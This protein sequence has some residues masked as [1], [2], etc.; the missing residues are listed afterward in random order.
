MRLA[1]IFAIFGLAIPALATKP[2]RWDANYIVKGTLYIPYAEIAEPFYAWYD[3]NT[4]RSRIDYYGGMVK[5]YQLANEHPYGTSLKLAPITTREELNK[6]TCLQLNGTAESPV[7]IQS[8]LPYVK[9]FTLMGTETFFG[10][11]L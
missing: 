9:D 1:L 3:K 4:N 11:H 8:I 2:P 6:V 7:E 10:F 5:T